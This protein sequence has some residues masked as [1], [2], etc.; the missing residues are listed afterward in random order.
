MKPEMQGAAQR[1]L[2][3]PVI[4]REVFV[5]V[6]EGVRIGDLGAGAGGSLSADFFTLAL[7]QAQA[8]A[9]GEKDWPLLYTPVMHLLT[10]D[11][12]AGWYLGFPV[13]SPFFLHNEGKGGTNTR[14]S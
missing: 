1:M 13:Q 5:L 9:P 12:S 7:P 14:P 6:G 2:P 11:G 4:D 3:H 10:G 8:R